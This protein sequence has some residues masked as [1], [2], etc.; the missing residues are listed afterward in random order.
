[1]KKIIFQTND[2]SI[3]GGVERVV[4]M[5]CNYF[6]KN[7]DD[8]YEIVLL[9]GSKEKSF[10]ELE[11][12]V[13]KEFCNYKPK[14]RVFPIGRIY[15][16]Y[17][18]LK[19]LNDDDVIIINKYCVVNSIYLLRKIG[20]FKNIKI[21]YF[22]HGG[23]SDLYTF[24]SKYRRNKIL[25]TFDN[26]ICLHN[27]MP[28]ADLCE[29]IKILPNPCTFKTDKKCDYNSKNIL[30]VGR[31]SHEKGV[32]L[33]IKSWSKTDRKDFKLI[34]VGDGLEKENLIELCRRLNLEDSVVFEG[35]KSNVEE[36]YLKSSIYAMTSRIEGLPMVLLEA[37]E[38]SMPIIAYSNAGTKNLVEDIGI[39]IDNFNE[40][41]YSKK[42]SELISD[43]SLREYLGKKS[44]IKSFNYDI[45]V[46]ALKIKKIIGIG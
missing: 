8:D 18:Y 14:Y 32:D 44:K 12:N 40:D 41:E 13:K 27:D 35:N 22:A 43:V 30:C 42:L 29:K 20:L 25:Y 28:E 6:S 37:M 10:Y 17:K 39:I 45:D 36:Y 2:M 9:T 15:S 33:L 24:Y 38:C 21:I 46:V 3:A 31:L 4:S 34:I 5:W 7:L 26:I 11:N 16:W 19:N 1:M 23:V